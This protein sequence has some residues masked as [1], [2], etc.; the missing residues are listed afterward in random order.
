MESYTHINFDFNLQTGIDAP[1]VVVTVMPCHIDVRI[2]LK[3][4]SIEG[5]KKQLAVIHEMFPFLAKNRIPVLHFTCTRLFDMVSDINALVRELVASPDEPVIPA[6]QIQVASQDASKPALSSD[7]AA[8][9][10]AKVLRR[11]TIILSTD[12]VHIAYRI[13]DGLLEG[14]YPEFLS[15]RNSKK[16]RINCVIDNTEGLREG[17][18]LEMID[19]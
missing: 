16:A 3:E 8:V 2:N 17:R 12:C 7:H 1:G 11:H 15:C 19:C 10:L 4:A 13:I 9:T 6:Q 5:V 18:H 14:A